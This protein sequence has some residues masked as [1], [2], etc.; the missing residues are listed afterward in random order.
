MKPMI[1]TKKMDKTIN[2]INK[3]RSINKGNS[4]FIFE[5]N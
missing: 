5:N 2:N 1:L 3:I 4:I